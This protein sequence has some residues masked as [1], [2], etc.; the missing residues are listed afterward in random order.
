[1][2]RAPRVLGV[3]F[4]Y[5]AALPTLPL[6]DPVTLSVQIPSV[7]VSR[8]IVFAGSRGQSP[9][10]MGTIRIAYDGTP[11]DTGT[12][13]T[14]YEATDLTFE[15]PVGLMRVRQFADPTPGVHTLTTTGTED[16]GPRCAW[17]AAVLLNEGGSASFGGTQ[18]PDGTLG[19]GSIAATR[20]V[21][22]CQ[23]H[24]S[25]TPVEDVAL[26]LTNWTAGRQI[27]TNG[28]LPQG[29]SIALYAGPGQGASISRTTTTEDATSFGT[30]AANVP[31]SADP[32]FPVLGE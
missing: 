32:R 15:N 1:M 28:A 9:G 4:N 25:A 24:Y 27:Y 16:V 5:E 6:A 7:S 23:W 21:V 3:W 18:Q 14:M 20:N 10:D 12:D 8:L 19:L 26:S 13:L 30:L 29:G 31:F 22:L 17:L 11:N 2:A